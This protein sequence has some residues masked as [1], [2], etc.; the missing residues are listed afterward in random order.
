M[1]RTDFL[2]RA[3][4]GCR[5]WIDAS[6][7]ASRSEVVGV[8][9]WRKALQVRIGARPREGEAND[10]LLRFLSEKLGIPRRAVS[11][12]RGEKSSA[13]AVEVPLTP[14]EVRRRLGV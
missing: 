6:P 1:G 9:E 12:V 4:D 3:G 8:N 14:E 2:E 10:E 11:L 7:G 5:I 13:K